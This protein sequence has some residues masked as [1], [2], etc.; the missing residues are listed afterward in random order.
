METDIKNKSLIVKK[1][2]AENEM[3]VSTYRNNMISEINRFMKYNLCDK[4]VI[5]SAI[6]REILFF[7]LS[8][9][10]CNDFCTF[11]K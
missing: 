5:C 6:S 11:S 1:F 3:Y 10:Y 7:R 4:I 9:M 8:S 2:W